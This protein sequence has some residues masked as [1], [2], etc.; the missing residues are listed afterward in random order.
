MPSPPR[1]GPSGQA[2]AVAAESAEAAGLEAAGAQDGGDAGGGEGE[3]P[4]GGVTARAVA[5]LGDTRTAQLAT[6]AE[7]ADLRCG[8]AKIYCYLSIY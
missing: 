1:E 8:V 7:Q 3:A 4:S 5:A 6:L 2:A